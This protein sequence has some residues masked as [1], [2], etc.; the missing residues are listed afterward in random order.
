METGP[1]MGTLL[2][3]AWAEMGNHRDYIAARAQ[4][5]RRVA[6]AES[7]ATAALAT[8]DAAKA[9]LTAILGEVTGAE[10]GN[11]QRSHYSAPGDTSVRHAAFADTCQ[12]QLGRL[13][14]GK[15]SF[16]AESLERMKR[17]KSE[18]ADVLRTPHLAP[19]LAARKR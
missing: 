2:G 8:K 11:L 16:D 1:G 19:R 4:L 9:L 5:S 14:G 15:L 7:R 3:L 18:L 12:G 17:S 10:K 6:E 13:S